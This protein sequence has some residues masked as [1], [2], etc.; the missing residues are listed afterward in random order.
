[1]GPTRSAWAL[2]SSRAHTRCGV[3][4]LARAVLRRSPAACRR[5]ALGLFAHFPGPPQPPAGGGGKWP[6]GPAGRVGAGRP[7]AGGSLAVPPAGPGVW[8]PALCAVV[9]ALAAPPAV[10]GPW[11]LFPP[12]PFF[13]AVVVLLRRSGGPSAGPL[14]P[15]P[16][17]PGRLRPR[18][19][20]PLP[21]GAAVAALFSVGVGAGVCVGVRP[22]RR[23]CSWAALLGFR[24]AAPRRAAAVV[25]VTFSPPATSR[26]PP[27]S[28]GARGSAGLA[29]S[30]RLCGLKIFFRRSLT[31][32]VNSNSVAP[33]RFFR[34]VVS[35]ENVNSR[36]F[37]RLTSPVFC[38][39]LSSQGWRGPA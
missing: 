2:A 7:P 12:A 37:A 14:F 34:R 28:G 39:M 19:L 23:G 9:A 16:V 36:F 5:A 29:L 17:A 21:P 8:P 18:R 31:A 6:F 30:V 38:A 22:L 1:M 15:G 27:P 24:C 13:G 35:T 32:A 11:A 33:Q 25:V 26:P 3:R 10:S 4:P 20:P